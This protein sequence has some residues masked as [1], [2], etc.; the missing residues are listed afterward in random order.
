MIRIPAS[1]LAAAI[2]LMLPVALFA[3]GSPKALAPFAGDY[4]GSGTH[5]RTLGS[6]LLQDGTLTTDSATLRVETPPRTAT[7]DIIST[8]ALSNGT[9][10]QVIWKLTFNRRNQMTESLRFVSGRTGTMATT[11]SIARGRVTYSGDIVFAGSPNVLG[12]VVATLRFTAAQVRI[13]ETITLTN[14]EVL[15]FRQTLRR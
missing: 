14:G 10:T 13:V 3:K 15:R 1:G 9:T 11:Y 7:F 12:R 6:T 4:S 2:L 5:T 8:L